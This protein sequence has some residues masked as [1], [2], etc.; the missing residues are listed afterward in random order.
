VIYTLKNV[1]AVLDVDNNNN[2]D[3]NNDDDDDDDDHPFTTSSKEMLKRKNVFSI[4]VQVLIHLPPCEI[5]NAGISSSPLPSAPS[6]MADNDRGYG[7]VLHEATT[8]FRICYNR[9]ALSSR[10]DYESTIHV[11]AEFI[12]RFPDKVD[13]PIFEMIEGS[14]AIVD[15]SFLQNKSGLET[16]LV[17]AVLETR[18]I[19]NDD[20]D[21]V[22]IRNRI[23]IILTK[24]WNV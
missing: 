11:C 17:D 18:E 7:E 23:E 2:D 16:A 22:D 3:N 12:K 20:A 1:V 21:I 15:R 9:S 4:S 19:G 6:W 8:F 13:A 10:A 14:C 24:F 5:N